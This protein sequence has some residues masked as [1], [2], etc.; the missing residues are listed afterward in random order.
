MIVLHDRPRNCV[1]NV[2]GA[3]AETEVFVSWR[4]EY[5]SMAELSEPG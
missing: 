3:T 2:L 1:V 4:D 5:L